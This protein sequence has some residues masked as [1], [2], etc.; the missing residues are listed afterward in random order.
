MNEE[1][2]SVTEI[3]KKTGIA[4][5]TVRRYIR[6]H[7]HHLQIKK[8]GKSYLIAPDSISIIQNIREL[9]EKGK[10][11]EEVGEFLRKMNMPV[12]ITMTD[13]E[14]QVTVNTSDVLIQLQKDMNEQ[15]KF[16]QVLLERLEKQEQ[17]IS[18]HL[19]KRDQQLLK[20]IRETMEDK[21][22]IELELKEKEE[23]PKG[24]FARLFKN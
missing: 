4:D 19:E 23:R 18:E 16:N 12:T 10:Q 11:S 14:K 3:E 8:R 20:S 9:Y 2:L 13:D 1:W 15:K 17:Y 21:K 24:L 22:R 7:G 6:N 5:S